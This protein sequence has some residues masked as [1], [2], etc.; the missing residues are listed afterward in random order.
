VSGRSEAPRA[1]AIAASA[2]SASKLSTRSAPL[3]SIALTENFMMIGA[4]WFSC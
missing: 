3:A 4:S 1:A 2:L